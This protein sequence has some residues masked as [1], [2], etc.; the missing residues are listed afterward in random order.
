M[1]NNVNLLINIKNRGGI[2]KLRRSQVLGLEN[3]F[4]ALM[5]MRL[6]P[7]VAYKV[8]SNGI[9]ANELSE[10]IRKSYKPVDGYNEVEDLRRDVLNKSG[11]KP[12]A[13][14]S[15]SVPSAVAT[16]VGVD[17]EAIN[18]K[19]KV[20]LDEQKAYQAKFDEMLGKTVEIAFETIERKELTGSIEPMKLVL[21]IQTGILT[22]GNK[23]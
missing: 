23:P 12:E 3:A 11:S 14:G 10:K 4:N 20:V 2:M 13:N 5:E 6:D 18:E 9:L 15:Y 19:H 22:N 1:L 8:A 17:L 7:E 16:Q 21:M